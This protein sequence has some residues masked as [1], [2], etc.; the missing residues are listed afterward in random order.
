[1]GVL[2]LQGQRD[3]GR[4]SNEDQGLV[5]A[6]TRHVAPAIS[7]LLA[8]ERH[9]VDSDHTQSI[10]KSLS[11]ESMVGKSA[12]LAA[13]LRDVELVAQRNVPVLIEGAS[14]TGKTALAQ[15]IHDNSRR[16]GGPFIELDCALLPEGLAESELFGAMPGSHS[17]AHHRTQGKVQ[18]AKGG[19][20]FLDEVA[21]LSL[22]VQA[23]LLQLL[24]SKQYFPLGG[25]QPLQADIRIIAATNADLGQRVRERAFRE[26]LFYRLSVLPIRMP[27]LS[28]RLEDI[29]LL[30]AHFCARFC[31][32]DELPTIGVSPWG[33]QALLMAEWPGNIRQ[34]ANTIRAGLLRSARER[35]ST[36]EPGTCFPSRPI[37]ETAPTRPPQAFSA[38]TRRRDSFRTTCS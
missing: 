3:V 38:T 14:G 19:T 7:R 17:T 15:V 24:Q 34:F 10:R 27:D 16:R 25:T 35:S 29:Q 13:V 23:K 2:Y 28:E 33:L 5:E 21:D 31:R 32:E 26:D 9:Q 8:L 4:F 1:M 12:A 18:A 37:L 22:K 36:I 20:L 30:A 11:A 6:F